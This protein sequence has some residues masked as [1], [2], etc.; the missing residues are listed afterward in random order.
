M[1]RPTILNRCQMAIGFSCR[2]RIV[3]AVRADDRRIRYGDRT[4][5]AVINRGQG[6][7]T[8]GAVAGAAILAN[9][10]RGGM[11]IYEG[12]RGGGCPGNG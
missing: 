1:A 2:Y 8:A 11:N 4:E 6:K 9:T 12:L 10:G 7:T 3:M 5:A